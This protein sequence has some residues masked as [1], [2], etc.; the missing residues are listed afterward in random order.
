MSQPLQSLVYKTLGVGQGK[1][2]AVEL[3]QSHDESVA[4][5]IKQYCK[6]LDRPCLVVDGASVDKH[7]LLSKLQNLF[8]IQQKLDGFATSSYRVITKLIRSHRTGVL[9]VNDAHLMNAEAEKLLSQLVQYARKHKLAWKFYFL[10]KRSDQASQLNSSFGVQKSL[11]WN[12]REGDWFFVEKADVVTNIGRNKASL[13]KCI[14]TALA[15][16]AGIYLFL[17]N[18]PEPKKILDI[19]SSVSMHSDER[20]RDFVPF[21]FETSHLS[22]GKENLKDAGINS[23]TALTV[24]SKAPES[25]LPDSIVQAVNDGDISRY[26]QLLLQNKGALRGVN[27]HGESLLVMAILARQ[28]LMVDEILSVR[29]DVNHQDKDG[30]TAL[31][32][33]SIS[34]QIEI[35]RMLIRYKSDVNLASKLFKT[36]LMAAVH[37]HHYDIAKL[38]ISNGAKINS[39]DH[40]GWTAMFYAVWNSRLDFVDLL[41]ENDADVGLLDESG[42]SLKQVAIMR[43][44]EEFQSQ[45]N[46]RI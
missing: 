30:H 27:E 26:K 22:G 36:P 39:Q 11:M 35:V 40:S 17:H 16:L 33:A 31:F 41:L 19:D 6:Q 5:R 18:Q 32:Y 1:V 38:L 45:L 24:F 43:G 8:G 23:N 9:C 37:N 2:F 20:Y 7:E 44:N 12:A 3:P 13:I 25:V 21:H 29:S 42:N 46:A 4:Q 34:G 14:A 15:V 10:S 28:E